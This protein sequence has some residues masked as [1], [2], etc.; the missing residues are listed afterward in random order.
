VLHAA[1]I[2]AV[3]EALVEIAALPE[4]IGRPFVVPVISE[5]PL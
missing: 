2:G 5:R 3:R 1:P 4:V